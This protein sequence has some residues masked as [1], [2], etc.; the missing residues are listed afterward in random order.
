MS[1]ERI[2]PCALASERARKKRERER[3]ILR[4]HMRS[5]RKRYSAHIDRIKRDNDL[6]RG[7][8]VLLSKTSFGQAN[9]CIVQLINRTTAAEDV[10][11]FSRYA[12]GSQYSAT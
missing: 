4:S 5:T 12:D 11:F 2:N 9:I 3:Q 6:S 1:R 10:P 8:P 7:I